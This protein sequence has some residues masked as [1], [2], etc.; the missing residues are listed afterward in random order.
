MCCV[1][2]RMSSTICVHRP[3]HIHASRAQ[4]Q[5]THLLRDVKVRAEPRCVVVTRS[6]VSRGVFQRGARE[7]T[8]AELVAAAA[9]MMRYGCLKKSQNAP[10]SSVGGEDVMGI[11][12]VER[13]GS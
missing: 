1:G 5:S 2:M 11:F 10:R 9:M 7:M 12:R 6:F 13:V 4:S 8:R 3:C